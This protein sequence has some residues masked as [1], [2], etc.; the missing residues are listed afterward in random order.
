MTE[1]KSY[2]NKEFLRKN[3]IYCNGV[4]I[5]KKT[6][7]AVG[8]DTK[9]YTMVWI[10]GQLYAIHRLIWI[11]HYGESPKQDIDHINRNRYDNRIEN[12]RVLTRSQNILNS[13]NRRN[14]VALK[15]VS[16]RK[17]RGCWRSYIRVDGVNKFLGHSW[18]LFDACCLRKSAELRFCP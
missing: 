2:P 1:I 11:Y 5:N 9:K 6:E 15:G 4:L 14:T 12:L 3:Y 16:F 18:T 13:G 10:G 17:E 7:R 8:S